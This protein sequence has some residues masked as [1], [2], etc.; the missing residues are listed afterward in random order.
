MHGAC[1]GKECH[2][3]QETKDRPGDTPPPRPTAAVQPPGQWGCCPPWTP[4]AG[5][6]PALTPQGERRAARRGAEDASGLQAQVASAHVLVGHSLLMPP[7][8]QV[9]KPSLC[10]VRARPSPA[11]WGHSVGPRRTECRPEPPTMTVGRRAS[12]CTPPPD[13]C[14]DSPQLRAGIPRAPS[15]RGLSP[16]ALAPRPVTPITARDSPVCV[17]GEGLP[18]THVWSLPHPYLAPSTVPSW[19]GDPLW[20]NTL[21]FR[22][23]PLLWAQRSPVHRGRDPRQHGRAWPGSCELPPP[24]GLSSECRTWGRQ[25]EA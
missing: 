5:T 3:R 21:S 23:C 10:P 9:W 17:C 4:D 8:P 16:P 13:W 12:T 25:A 20:G 14:E 24:A 11:P 18:F 7:G 15:R 6:P 2:L 1:S 22:G 19:C